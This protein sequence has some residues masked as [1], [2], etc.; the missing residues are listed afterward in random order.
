LKAVT[1]RE[2]QN[3]IDRQPGLGSELARGDSRE[4]AWQF[5]HVNL[6]EETEF[7][8]VHAEDRRA[9]PVGQPHGPEHGAVPAEADDQVRSPAEVPGRYGHDVV[10]GPVY[11][12]LQAEHLGVLAGGPVQALLEE[13]RHVVEIN[14]IRQATHGLVGH[15][16]ESCP[17]QHIDH[18]LPF[19]S[20]RKFLSSKP[21]SV[22]EFPGPGFPPTA[23]MSAV[24]PRRCWRGPG[25]P[26]PSNQ[27]TAGSRSA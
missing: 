3:G 10:S 14:R 11:L 4:R 2:A 22:S 13:C 18:V 23:G 8:Q 16:A 17:A 9:L 12:V 20:I 7:A 26:G 21:E 5:T 24:R 1:R 15:L 27:V 6:S 19:R 25:C